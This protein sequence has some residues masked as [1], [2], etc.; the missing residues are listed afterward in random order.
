LAGF[1]VTLI[2]R[3]W[4]TPEGKMA[5]AQTLSISSKRPDHAHEGVCVQR[6]YQRASRQ[7]PQVAVTRG[8]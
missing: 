3:I 7:I 1:Q 6:G 2:G 4:V 5:G 8:V